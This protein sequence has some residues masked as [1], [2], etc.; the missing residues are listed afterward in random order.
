MVI[1]RY[2][3]YHNEAQKAIYV[4][5]RRKKVKPHRRGDDNDSNNRMRPAKQVIIFHHIIRIAFGMIPVIN[6]K[7]NMMA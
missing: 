3:K 4:C 5:E 7:T 2:R 1:G 6:V